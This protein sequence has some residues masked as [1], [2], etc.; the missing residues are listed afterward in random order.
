VTVLITGG[1]GTGK[2]LVARAIY[3]HGHRA[4]KPLLAVNWAAIPETLLESELFGHEKG[5]FTGS[6]RKR[7]GKFEQCNGGPIFL[8]EVGEMT[9]LTQAKAL[10]LIQEQRFER[11]GG[12]DTVQSDVRVIAAT[13]ADLDKMVEDGR[14]RSARSAAERTSVRGL[15]VRLARMLSH[16]AAN[17]FS[18]T[19]RSVLK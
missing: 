17:R 10:R 6:Y 3:E 19:S 1:S 9:P 12:D 14:F 15:G 13:N 11:V 4:D 8:D 16:S 2:E 18:A 7:I 5:S